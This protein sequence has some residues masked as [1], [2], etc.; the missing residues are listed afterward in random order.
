MAVLSRL[1]KSPSG[2]TLRQGRF[3]LGQNPGQGA[4]LKLMGTGIAMFRFVYMGMDQYL[5]IPFL[6][7]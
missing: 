7:G 3:L 5:L 6:V 4:S 2:A 1:S